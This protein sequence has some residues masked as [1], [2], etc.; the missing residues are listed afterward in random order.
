MDDDVDCIKHVLDEALESVVSRLIWQQM[1]PSLVPLAPSV[2]V[3]CRTI[4]TRHTIHEPLYQ[5]VP[6]RHAPRGYYHC[7]LKL[8]LH[9]EWALEYLPGRTD[10]AVRALCQDGRSDR[11]RGS[12]CYPHVR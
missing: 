5:V 2:L 3:P 4:N 10:S 7:L 8:M 11:I 9:D 6:Y 1:M 12:A